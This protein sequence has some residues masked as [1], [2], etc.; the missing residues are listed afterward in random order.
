VAAHVRHRQDRDAAPHCDLHEAGVVEEVDLVAVTE[1]A[2]TVELTAGI[3]EDHR[4]GFERAL[5]VLRG[6][7]QGPHLHQQVVHDRDLE[8]DVVNHRVGGAVGADV[9]R[10][11]AEDQPDVR[12]DRAA[13]V[14][15]DRHDGAARWNMLHALVL[16]PEVPARDGVDQRRDRRDELRV[17]IVEIG[18][19]HPLEDQLAEHR[20]P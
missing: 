18:R 12:H 2:K 20:E 10:P 11:P 6:R 15:A 3:D 7:R 1:R 9:L 4:A 14:V 17:A 13:V 5:G 16:E 19:I 8:D